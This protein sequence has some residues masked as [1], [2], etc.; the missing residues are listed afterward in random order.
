MVQH[1]PGKPQM[2]VAGAALD[3]EMIS[4]TIVRAVKCGGH[5]TMSMRISYIITTHLQVVLSL[6]SPTSFA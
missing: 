6:G 4:L 5:Y 3:R 1:R 2:Q